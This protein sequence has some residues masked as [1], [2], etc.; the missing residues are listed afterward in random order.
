MGPDRPF[1]DGGL[2][3]SLAMDTL[4]I[5]NLTVDALV[6]VHPHEKRIRQQLRLDLALEVDMTSA[7]ATDELADALDYVSVCDHLR[8]HIRQ[9]RRQLIESLAESCAQTLLENYPIA[10]ISLTLRKPGALAGTP[11]V[12]VAIRRERQA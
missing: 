11:V 3:L 10:V 9:S 2:K 6:G 1:A 12:G 8:D 7:A 4:L 5:E